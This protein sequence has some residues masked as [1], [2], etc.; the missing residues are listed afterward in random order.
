VIPS[1]F[2]LFT[3]FTTVRGVNVGVGHGSTKG[4]AK[5]NASIQALEYLKTHGKEP[6]RPID[7]I[8]D[9]EIFSSTGIVTEGKIVRS[10]STIEYDRFFGSDRWIYCSW[11]SKWT[12]HSLSE[13]TNLTFN[14]LVSLY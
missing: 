1:R 12:G 6:T 5:R 2:L 10:I 9:L 4:I 11:P 3:F 8:T 13:S 7:R 14:L